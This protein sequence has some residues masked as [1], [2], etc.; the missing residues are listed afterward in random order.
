[1]KIEHI[2]VIP[3]SEYVFDGTEFVAH[4]GLMEEKDLQRYLDALYTTPV[5]RRGIKRKFYYA[6]TKMI[7]DIV[8]VHE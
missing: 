2:N 8:R 3:V 5:E 6:D 4:R 1:M 7:A